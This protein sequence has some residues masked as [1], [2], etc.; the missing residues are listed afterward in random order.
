MIFEEVSENMQIITAQILKHLPAYL[1]TFFCYF[2]RQVTK[3]KHRNKS[4]HLK[5][6]L[7]QATLSSRSNKCPGWLNNLR[8]HQKH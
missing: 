4:Q 6:S 5:L 2:L 8:R 7:L 3:I 1:L